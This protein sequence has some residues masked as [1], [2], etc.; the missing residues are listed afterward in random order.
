MKC[1]DT[2]NSEDTV[3]KATEGDR[4]CRSGWE[5]HHSRTDGLSSL[6]VLFGAL[7]VDP[8]VIEEI[9]HAANHVSG[10]QD[11]AEVRVRWVDPGL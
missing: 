6:A 5:G 8:E 2:H 4:Q 3:R 10:V 9:K 11:I 1:A 7:G